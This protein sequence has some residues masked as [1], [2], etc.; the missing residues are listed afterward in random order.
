MVL[1]IK[2][3]KAVFELQFEIKELNKEVFGE[4]I[5]VTKY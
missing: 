2:K 3:K 1:L 5:L 4:S